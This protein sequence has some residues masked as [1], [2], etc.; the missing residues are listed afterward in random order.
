MAAKSS[1]NF[2][3]RELKS[4]QFR[5]TTTG[6]FIPNPVGIRAIG[7]GPKMVATMEE[8]SKLVLQASKELARSEAYETGEYYRGL[9][10]ISGYEGTGFKKVAASRVNAWDFKSH[11]IEWGTSRGFQARHILERAAEAVGLKVQVGRN[12]R[13][14]L[15]SHTERVAR[16]A[17][18]SR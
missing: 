8:A 9:R 4:G 6:K 2:Q 16:L 7:M 15:G 10:N 11:W 18:R 14:I 12:T 3:F 13:R 17:K 5:S 1:G